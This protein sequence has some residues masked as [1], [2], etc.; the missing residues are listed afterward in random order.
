[1]QLAVVE[2]P[3]EGDHHDGGVLRARDDRVAGRTEYGVDQRLGDRQHRSARMPL[4]EVADQRVQR[5]D[6]VLRPSG[7]A[8]PAQ[9]GGTVGRP[10][11][12][13]VGDERDAATARTQFADRLGGAGQQPFAEVHRAVQI[14]GVP[15]E[16]PPRRA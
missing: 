10:A 5:G 8:E 14:E 13:V 9:P 7:Q 16:A 15:G 2:R 1:V 12:R 4:G 3:V 6:H 11:Q